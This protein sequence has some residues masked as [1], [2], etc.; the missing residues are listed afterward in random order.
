M[1]LL[2]E[3]HHLSRIWLVHEIQ[4]QLQIQI[5]IQIPRRLIASIV[6]TH[7][8]PPPSHIWLVME[9]RI[10]IQIQIKIQILIQIQI[11]RRL[12]ASIVITHRRPPPSLTSDWLLVWWWLNSYS[13]ELIQSAP[14]LVRERVSLSNTKQIQMQMQ[15]QIQLFSFVWKVLSQMVRFPGKYKFSFGKPQG[16]HSLNWCDP[17]LCG[18]SAI[19]VQNTD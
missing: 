6:I 7:R 1:S 3:D 11:N 9:I 10:Q 14:L 12:V 16:R 18:W 15:I 2:T 13:L 4:I 5:K 17:G 8:R 19:F